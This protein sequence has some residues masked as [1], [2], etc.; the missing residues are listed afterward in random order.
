MRP[1]SRAKGLAIGAVVGFLLGCGGSRGISL[2]QVSEH[3]ETAAWRVTADWPIEAVRARLIGDYAMARLDKAAL[4]ALLKN[5]PPE[6]DGRP[7]VGIALPM[8]DGSLARFRVV[9]SP[10]LA[11]ALAAAFPDIRTY[12]GQGLDDKTTT[13][14]FGWTELGFHAVVL[15]SGGSVFIDPIK[16][17][18]LDNYISYRKAPCL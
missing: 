4:D 13:P 7:G 9:E 12:S 8:P 1:N 15:H 11:P 2:A 17:G 5:T 6:R 10:I 14:R 18:D 3:P 16:P